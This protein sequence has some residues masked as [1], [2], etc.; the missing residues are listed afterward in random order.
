M[1]NSKRVARRPL[2]APSMPPDFRAAELS[3]DGRPF[4][5]MSYELPRWEFPVA[6]TPAERQVLL[7][8]L[9][10]ETHEEVAT[11]RGISSRTVANQI[12]S[13]FKK[14]GVRSRMELAA[15]LERGA[16]PQ[17]QRR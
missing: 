12:A 16:P 15:V 11:A 17:S 2:V 4:L 3:A 10:G 8:V 13:A 1:A 9:D 5:V 14:I 7:R 6:L